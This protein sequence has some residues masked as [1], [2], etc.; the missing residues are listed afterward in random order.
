MAAST[1]SILRVK[2]LKVHFPVNQGIVFQKQVATVRAVD[3]VSF[4]LKRG[5]TLGLVVTAEGIER[6]TQ[7]EWLRQRGCDEGQGYLLARPLAPRDL[8]LRFLCSGESKAADPA[9]RR[10]LI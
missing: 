4:D 3:G 2:D 7:L 1:E 10:S 8:E 5:E 9:V 6:T